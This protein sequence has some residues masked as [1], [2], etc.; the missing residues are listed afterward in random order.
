GH[1][2]AHAAPRLSCLE[3]G[4]LPARRTPVRIGGALMAELKIRSESWGKSKR[5]RELLDADD[6]ESPYLPLDHEDWAEARR[7]A[8]ADLRAAVPLSKFGVR[9]S[10]LDNSAA[11]TDALNSG[12]ELSAPSGAVYLLAEPSV[13]TETAKFRLLA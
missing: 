3:M 1:E 10:S 13:R 4:R 11:L 9:T 7:I 2:H 12:E 8:L 6:A 5:I